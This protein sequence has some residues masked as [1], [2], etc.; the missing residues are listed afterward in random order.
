M[1]ILLTVTYTR[2]AREY[3]EALARGDEI[4]ALCARL[5]GNC[6]C[7][8]ADG[9]GLCP[10]GA[11]L[12][13]E[14]PPRIA[15]ITAMG[16]HAIVPAVTT[17]G[18]AELQAGLGSRVRAE[19][20]SGAA[21]H[22]VN[23]LTG[24]HRAWLSASADP[25]YELVRISCHGLAKTIG[26]VLDDVQNGTA[27]EVWDYRRDRLFGYLSWC[28]PRAIEELGDV[29]LQYTVRARRGT[30]ART[31]RCEFASPNDTRAAVVA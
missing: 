19:L 29:A 30:A 12:A 21:V 28:P 5:L 11:A 27:F 23:L 26:S 20:E 14:V 4:E 9:C 10:F 2:L 6:R 17:I 22:V 3:L 18:S 8:L 13:A 24:R 31:L 25:G 15:D 1:P 7:E 16:K